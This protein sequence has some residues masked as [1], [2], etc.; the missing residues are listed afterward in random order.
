VD[1]ITT[2]FTAAHPDFG[3]QSCDVRLAY[4]PASSSPE[5]ELFQSILCGEGPDDTSAATSSTP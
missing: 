4:L 1:G 5:T 2:S 3:F